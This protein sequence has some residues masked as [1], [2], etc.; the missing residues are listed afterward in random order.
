METEKRK[1]LPYLV[2]ALLS[3][4]ILGPLLLP[5]YILTLDMLFTPDMDSTTQLYGLSESI[6]ARS[7]FLLSMQVVSDIIPAWLLQKVILF[8]IFFLAGLGAHK[9]VPFKGAG[10]Y[11]AGLLY[12]VNPFT[13]VRFMAGQWPLLAAY[14]LIPFGVKAFLELLEKG[15]MKNTIKL[16]LLSTLVGVMLIH[17]L[18]LLLLVFLVIF[19]VKLINERKNPARLLQISR[20]VG[21]SAAMFL[22]LNVY[23]L[24]PVL[25]AGTARLEQIG[26]A[27]LLL[28]APKAVG[29]A[30]VAFA[31]A[32]MHGFWNPGWVY[33][34][35]FIPFWP[36]LFVFILFLAVYGF[37]SILKDKKARWVTISLAVVGIV[38]FAFAAG[39][40]LKLTRPVFEWFFN[41]L[42][43]VRG[44]RD[45][46][47]FVA[48][49]CLSYAYLGGLGVETL[50]VEFRQRRK[51]LRRVGANVFIILALLVPLFYSFPIF[52][53]WGQL[54]ATDYPEEWYEINDYLNQDDDD[55]NVLF[56]PWH[57]YMD[58][59]WLPNTNKR[60]ASPARQFFNKP[61]ISGDN[62]EA[63]GKYS[64]S[65]NPISKYV[66]FL[67]DNASNVNNLGELLAPLNVKYVLL[68][69][70]VGYARY[71]FLY[72]QEDL[73]VELEKP[74]ITLLKNEHPTAR[75]CG[76]NSVVYIN[77]L[78]EYL[79][80]STKQ[81]IMKHLYVIG[82]GPSDDDNAQME[83]LT[84]IEKNS[85][86][87][88]ITGSSQSYI[89][90][91]VPQ[92]VTTQ[93]W[94]YNDDKPLFQN[95][96]F[97]PAFTSSP[98]EGE[99]VYT[100]FYYVYLPSYIISV[101]V[102]GFMVYF[103]F[104]CSKQKR[105]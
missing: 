95:L 98:N 54:K 36:V 35:N 71:N 72:Q 63:G 50:S 17:G 46:Q 44:F 42:V 96:G 13:Y 51:R 93:Y 29:E 41:N 3:L 76:V 61:I 91:T 28:F 58:Y 31:L 59:S 22:V 45:S 4:A 90:F 21:I 70:E 104:H 6:S 9:L 55:F 65:T 73:T 14:A 24:I 78:E 10:S 88:Q 99:V 92:N 32:S 1:W 75:A 52:G 38:S 8:L 64:G 74:N 67:L 57:Q 7:P 40:T 47:K 20:Y 43:F 16:I 103:Y 97:M 79:E 56:L 100:R 37:L 30:G 23:W 19:V 89:V 80:L 12:M 87:Y 102:L 33:A 18:F 27:D 86:K 48:L 105:L 68:V 39:A 85:V 11:F 25:T 101:I 15:G 77:S 94:E 5:G 49:L 60:V 69:H 66:E 84:V 34:S 81:D 62:I 83:K 26:Q 82:S 53:S 2:Y